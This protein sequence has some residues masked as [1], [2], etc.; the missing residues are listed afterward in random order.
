MEVRKEVLGLQELLALLERKAQR[1]LLVFKGPMEQL[2][3]KEYKE[4]QE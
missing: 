4:V 1:D 2:E 3:H